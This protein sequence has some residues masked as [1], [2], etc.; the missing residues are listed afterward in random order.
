MGWLY[1]HEILAFKS[2]L[3]ELTLNK[4]YIQLVQ[5]HSAR[6]RKKK[7]RFDELSPSAFSH[8]EAPV[9]FS[10]A[11]D[12]SSREIV[13]DEALGALSKAERGKQSNPVNKRREEEK[14]ESKGLP[15]R[16]DFM[17]SQVA[18][19]L[20]GDG[21][22]EANGVIGAA[23]EKSNP[24]SWAPSGAS[25]LKGGGSCAFRATEGCWAVI[26]KSPKRSP[27]PKFDEVSNCVVGLMG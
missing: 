1:L 16:P 12:P 25:K 20:A 14:E 2:F 10:T 7:K 9:Y 23:K 4:L 21:E 11:T 5:R 6:G 13:N 19:L 15:A 26:M 22:E 27:P 18:E 17:A 8:K 24:S 3:E